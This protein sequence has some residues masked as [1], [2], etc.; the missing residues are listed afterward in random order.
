MSQLNFPL[1][2][3]SSD[4]SRCYLQLFQLSLLGDL[5]QPVL[6]DIRA[7]L[8]PLMAEIETDVRYLL[9]CI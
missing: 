1:L 3:D 9:L 6:S 2:K 4:K 8:T 5:S 7:I